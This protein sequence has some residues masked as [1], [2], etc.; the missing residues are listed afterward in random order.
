M[1]QEI[2]M[3]DGPVAEATAVGIT[4]RPV[5]GSSQ[6]ATEPVGLIDMPA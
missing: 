5:G 3:P 2:R 4:V 6:P 1:M